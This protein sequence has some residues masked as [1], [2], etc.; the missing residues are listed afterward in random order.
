M[1]GGGDLAAAMKNVGLGE[2]ELL[3]V[4]CFLLPLRSQIVSE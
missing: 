3:D 1:A 2:R 4:T